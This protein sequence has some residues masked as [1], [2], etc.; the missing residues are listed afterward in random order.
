MVWVDDDASL[1]AAVQVARQGL[2]LWDQLLILALAVA[3]FEPWV[4]NRLSKRRGGRAD[5]ALDRRT[6]VAPGDQPHSN[7]QREVA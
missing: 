5:D 7:P 1:A 2:G 3:L 4:A 6:V